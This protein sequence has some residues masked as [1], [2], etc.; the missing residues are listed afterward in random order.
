MEVHMGIGNLNMSIPEF[1]H[2]RRTFPM[3]KQTARLAPVSQHKASL[4]PVRLNIRPK[5]TECDRLGI[6]HEQAHC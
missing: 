5:R 4:I 6:E 1:L 3:N 2:V